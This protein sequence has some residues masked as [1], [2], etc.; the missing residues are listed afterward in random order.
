[1]IHKFERVYVHPSQSPEQVYRDYL[2]S[3]SLRQINHKFHYDSVKQSQKWLR[4]H[5]RFSPSR[6]NPDCINAYKNCFQKAASILDNTSS[7]QLIGLGCGGGTKD[8]TLVSYLSNTEK[9]SIYYP[10]DVSLSL[11]LIAAQKVRASYPNLS[12]QPIVC[13]LL[14][15][16]DLIHLINKEGEADRTVITFFGML[17]NF[18]PDQIMPILGNFLQKGDLLLLSANLAPGDDYLKGI[19]KIFD[20]YDN[21]L[22]K[23]WLMTILIDAGV[24]QENGQII[25]YIENDQKTQDLKRIGVYFELRNDLNLELE[26]QLIQWAHGNKVQLFFSYRYNTTMI[27]KILNQYSINILDYW[28]AAN[29]EEGIYLCQKQ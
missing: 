8:N 11:A 22:T 16:D 24:N 10:V 12:V 9:K 1:M 3:F 28:E 21:E 15:A 5:E 25:S 29:Q 4:I 18:P 27:Q 19:H 17:P 26:D 7:W 13:D 23:D 2:A 20:Q 14:H 6:N